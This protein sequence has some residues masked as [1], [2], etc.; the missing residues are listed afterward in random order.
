MSLHLPARQAVY[1]ARTSMA[2]PSLLLPR[3][4]SRNA[5]WLSSL[6][7]GKKDVDTPLSRELTRREKE[8][9][10]S[11]NIVKRTQG[12]SIFDEEIKD[13]QEAKGTKQDATLSPLAYSNQREHMQMA[14]DP[15]PRWRVRFQRKKIMQ[16]VRADGQLSKEEQIKRTEKEL[17]SSSGYLPTSTKKL[18]HLSHQIAGKTVEDAITQMRFSKKRMAREVLFQLEEA[19]DEAVAKRG[20]GLG[21]VNGEATTAKARTIKTKDGRNLEVQDPTRLYVDESWVTKGPRRGM[22]IQYHARGRMSQMWRPTT[23]INMVLK[24][25]K[26]RIRQHDERVAKE[27]K[28]APWVH[29]PNRP[30]TAQRQYYSW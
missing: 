23:S 3:T 9:K 24:E 21:A 1:A 26:T 6:F 29:L 10:I 16:M 25:E 4:Q 20:M 11:E 30:V 13:S 8:K 22:R 5:S 15:D 7:G 2:K 19:R 14:L 17:Q 12:E 28:K 27:A 18:V